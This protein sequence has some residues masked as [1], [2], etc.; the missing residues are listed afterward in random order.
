ML[1]VQAQA[2]RACPT[3]LLLRQAF[4]ELQWPLWL[5]NIQATSEGV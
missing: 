4:S 1:R 3:Q 5:F 2:C